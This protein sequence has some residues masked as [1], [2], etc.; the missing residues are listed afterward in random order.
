MSGER[1]ST[2]LEPSYFFTGLPFWI[3]GI[4]A[5]VHKAMVGQTTAKLLA[6]PLS[7]LAPNPAGN[8]AFAAPDEIPINEPLLPKSL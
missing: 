8:F 6:Q 7:G 1:P 4:F 3:I 5:D 2:Q